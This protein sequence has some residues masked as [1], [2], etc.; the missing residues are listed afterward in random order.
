[1]IELKIK[2][3]EEQFDLIKRYQE[4]GGF[5]TVSDALRSLVGQGLWLWHNFKG[6]F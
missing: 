5:S 2:V 6:R 1:M 3:T 4:F